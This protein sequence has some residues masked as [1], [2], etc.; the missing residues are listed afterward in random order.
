VLSAQSQTDHDRTL[1][2][3]LRQELSEADAILSSL[4]GAAPSDWTPPDVDLDAFELA[5]RLPVSLPS[6]LVHRRPDISAAEAQL[7]AASAAFGTATADLYPHLT[8]NA[9]IGEQGLLGGGP[10]ETA[11]NILGGLTAPVFPDSRAPRRRGRIPS[12]SC[13]IS[14]DRT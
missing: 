12:G 14:T 3:P 6:E 5:E 4:I 11:W 7:H 10:S 1:L 2:P 8:L 13:H 9:A